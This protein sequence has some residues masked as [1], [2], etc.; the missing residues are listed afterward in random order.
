MHQA[1]M[2]EAAGS[3]PALVIK[4]GRTLVKEVGSVS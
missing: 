4:P 2:P 3:N 1:K